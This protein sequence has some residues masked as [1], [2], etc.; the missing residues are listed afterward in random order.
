MT[1]GAKGALAGMFKEMSVVQLQ[2][3]DAARR[4]RGDLQPDH[5]AV[6]SKWDKLERFSVLGL[7]AL[8]L[9]KFTLAAVGGVG[10]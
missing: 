1:E 10:R 5:T 6:L 4:W 7:K 9:L 2:H 8:C 3:E